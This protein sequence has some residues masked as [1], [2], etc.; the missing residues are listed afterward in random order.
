LSLSFPIIPRKLEGFYRKRVR[1]VNFTE[2]KTSRF[3]AEAL[4]KGEL[5]WRSTS[6][7]GKFLFFMPSWTII[8]MI[9]SPGNYTQLSRTEYLVHYKIKFKYFHLMKL[10]FGI[11]A[12]IVIAIICTCIFLFMMALKPKSPVKIEEGPYL[13][14]ENDRYN[15]ISFKIKNGELVIDTVAI[16]PNDKIRV[17]VPNSD[18][19]FQVSLDPNSPSLSARQKQPEKI[20]VLSDIEGNFEYLEE[21]LKGNNVIDENYKW[22]FGNGHLVILGD[23]FDRG[24]HVTE[25]LWLIYKLDL[26]ARTAGGQVHFI[27]GNHEIMNLTGDYRYVPSK[28]LQMAQKLGLD[29]KDLFGVK[30]ELGRWLR[31]KNTVEVLGQTL[32][33]HG[34]LSPVAA[35]SNLSLD[36]IN[37]IVRKYIDTVPYN[38]Q[39]KNVNLIIGSNGP[40]WYRG[41]ATQKASEEELSRTLDQYNVDNMVIGHTLSD[42]VKT[43]YDKKVYLIDAKRHNKNHVALLIQ[44]KN[45]YKVNANASKTK[46]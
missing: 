35:E 2:Q 44:N 23:V 45:F 13:F 39:D 28:Y 19:S 33:A 38:K 30:T 42:D 43:I 26:E 12:S 16:N 31:S 5:A 21:V 10:S 41:Y 8:I 24:K 36:T 34:G 4:G 15:A 7:V 3:F 20:L 11:L 40:L 37:L 1:R 6:E 18:Q 27:L 46:L 25:C 14:L 9:I 22:G 17:N 32:F 29:Y